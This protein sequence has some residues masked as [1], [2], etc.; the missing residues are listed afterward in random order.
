MPKH[1]LVTGA[2]GFIGSALIKELVNEGWY[3][4]AATREP[5]PALDSEHI[6]NVSIGSINASTLWEDALEG[7]DVVVHLA[8]RVH[9]M[10]DKTRNPLGAYRKVNVQGSRKLAEIASQS[11]VKRLVL[12]SSVKVNGEEHSRAYREDDEPEPQDPYGISKMEGELA[13]RTIADGSEMD[14]V[15][16]RPPLVYGAGV[17]ANFRALL[18]M[19]HRKVPLPLA[20][21]NNQRSLIYIGNLVDSII[22]CMTSKAA[23]NQTYLV[24]DDQ[25]LSTPRLI[26]AIAASMDTRCLLFPF[27]QL[28]LKTASKLAG[29]GDAA[30]RLL[31][32]LTVD[33]SKIKRELAW[34][35]PFSVESGLRHTAKWYKES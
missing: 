10:S 12:L 25:D 28:L 14:Y 7:M 6:R 31:G 32:S 11:G 33:I 4:T 35:P 34:R 22:A 13:L 29:K 21:V 1:V 5:L 30:N 23:A 18:S 15:I 3:V 9:V 27:P 2:N 8:A 24:S 26:R 16:I 17:K 20:G 19:V